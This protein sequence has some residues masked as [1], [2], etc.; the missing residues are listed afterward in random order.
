MSAAAE[1]RRLGPTGVEV[2]ALA[3]GCAPLAGLFS[4]VGDERARATVD[5]AWRAGLRTFCKC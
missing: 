1:R 2:T 4:A 3:L 5:A